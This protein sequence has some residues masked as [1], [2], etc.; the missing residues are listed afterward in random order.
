MFYIYTYIRFKYMYFKHI[1]QDIPYSIVLKKILN[2]S[3]IKCY[4]E[5]GFTNNKT[6]IWEHSY[7]KINIILKLVF[8][9]IQKCKSSVF[10]L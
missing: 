6:T 10:S 7:A 3:V 5:T 9:K 8:S 1:F 2:L 4:N